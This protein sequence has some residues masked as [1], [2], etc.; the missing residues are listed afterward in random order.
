MEVPRQYVFDMATRVR[1]RSLPMTGCTATS[2]TKEASVVHQQHHPLRL[3]CYACSPFNNPLPNH[4]REKE[5]SSPPPTPPY[6]LILQE[7]E[8]AREGGGIHSIN[9]S[10]GIFPLMKFPSSQGNPRVEV[11]PVLFFTLAVLR[12]ARFILLSM[13]TVY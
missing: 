7:F 9:I 6:T 11:N 8:R 1:R 5:T 2:S 10:H 12:F 3:S 4:L 13:T